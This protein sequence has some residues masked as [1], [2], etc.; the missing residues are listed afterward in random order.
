[1][2]LRYSFI[3]S[4]PLPFYRQK[5]DQTFILQTENYTASIAETIDKHR[6]L[7][8]CLLDS[9]SFLNTRD[10]E[11]EQRRSKI[12]YIDAVSLSCNGTRMCNLPLDRRLYLD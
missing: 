11:R 9:R 1:M 6:Q 8:K 7:M 4:P 5:S 2:C 12:F 10:N 3:R